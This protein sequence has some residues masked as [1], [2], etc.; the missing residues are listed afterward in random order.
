MEFVELPKFSEMVD[1]LLTKEEFRE[2]QNE[3]IITPEKGDLIQGTGGAR[4]ARVR[5]GVS[6]KSGGA[7]AIYHY[8]DARQRI[9]L[10]AI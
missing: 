5:Y 1:D 6:G 8:V 7:R 9:W 3:L 10:L 4:K 2:F